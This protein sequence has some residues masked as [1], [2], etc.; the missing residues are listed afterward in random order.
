MF[1]GTC[2]LMYIN[3]IAESF[4]GK[5]LYNAYFIGLS[6]GQDVWGTIA[7]RIVG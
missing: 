4:Y 6:C 7:V 5:K 2:T 1:Q 3:E